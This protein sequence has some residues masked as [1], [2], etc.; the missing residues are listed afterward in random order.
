M[1]DFCYRELEELNFDEFTDE[2]KLAL[3][4]KVEKE[5]IRVLLELCGQDKKKRRDVFLNFSQSLDGEEAENH[6]LHTFKKN[7]EQCKALQELSKPK[8]VSKNNRNNNASGNKTKRNRAENNEVRNAN[9]KAGNAN[10]EARNANSE[11]EKAGIAG[12]VGVEAEKAGIAGNV[13]VE[14]EKA[15][16][17]GNVGVE[18]EKAGIAGKNAPASA[19]NPA[20]VNTSA[21]APAVENPAANVN[22]PAVNAAANVNVPAVNAPANTSANAPAVNASAKVNA[23]AAENPANVNV[24]GINAPAANVN[25]PAVNAAAK[26]NA[27]AAENPANVNAAEKAAVNPVLKGGSNDPGAGFGFMSTYV[28]EDITKM[29]FKEMEDMGQAFSLENFVTRLIVLYQI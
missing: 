8:I 19:N 12:N 5:K 22:V 27:P 13:G 16:I 20:V 29:N 25:V 21:N 23:P 2:D 1:Y 9:A 17:A 28:N 3:K 18:A 10:A 6:K 4:D 7:I 26:V 11:A 15:G 14:A 24:P